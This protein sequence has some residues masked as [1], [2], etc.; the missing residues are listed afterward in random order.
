[1]S[2]F[3]HYFAGVRFDIVSF[4]FLRF[5]KTLTICSVTFGK[6]VNFPE[7]LSTHS[8]ILALKVLE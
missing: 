4:L 3:A 1:M 8:S 6:L 2:K 5:I 7:L